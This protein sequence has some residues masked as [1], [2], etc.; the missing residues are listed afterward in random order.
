MPP[1]PSSRAPLF[2]L[3]ASVTLGLA[4]AGCSSA[5]APDGEA[6]RVQAYVGSLSVASEVR[7]SFRSAM[8]DTVDC[9]DFAA[10]PGVLALLGYYDANNT[11]QTAGSTI[12][13]TNPEYVFDISTAPGV[14][15]WANYFYFGDLAPKP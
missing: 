15:T 11:L 4:W 12:Y 2:R 5:P 6:A 1:R 13:N 8:G 7:H 3:A 10:A 14:A 9:A